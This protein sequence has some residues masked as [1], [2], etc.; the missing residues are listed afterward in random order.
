MGNHDSL[1]Q[2]ALCQLFGFGTKADP[3]AATQ[4]LQKILDQEAP[5]KLCQ[6]TLE[7]ARY[8]LGISHLMGL[9]R[10]KKSVPAARELLERAN[11]DDDHEQA[12]EFFNLIGKTQYLDID[13]KNA[14]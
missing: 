13:K 4:G 2:V 7:D 10:L 14:S 11:A 8:W 9:G 6:H 1:L 12:N 5:S 3:V